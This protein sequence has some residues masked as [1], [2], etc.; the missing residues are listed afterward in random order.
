MV[1]AKTHGC[2]S[3]HPISCGIKCTAAYKKKAVMYFAVRLYDYLSRVYV[4]VTLT[5]GFNRVALLV[6][7]FHELTDTNFITFFA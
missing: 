2:F 4:S 7:S 5:G 3:S 1:I 6:K